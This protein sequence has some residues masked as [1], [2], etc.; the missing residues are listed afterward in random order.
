MT[1]AEQYRHWLARRWFRDGYGWHA[2][3][4][5]GASK[6]TKRNAAISS[7]WLADNYVEQDEYGMCRLTPVGFD[8]LRFPKL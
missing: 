5:F 6:K 1:K 3:D 2:C 4:G 7:K 8:A